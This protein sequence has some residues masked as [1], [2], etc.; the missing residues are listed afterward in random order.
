MKGADDGS[1]CLPKVVSVNF[2]IDGLI[3]VLMG[4][5]LQDQWQVVGIEE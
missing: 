1:C 3:Y 5:E 2:V 4:K